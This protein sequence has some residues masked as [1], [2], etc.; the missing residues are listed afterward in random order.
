[1]KSPIK[2]KLCLNNTSAALRE[3]IP[4]GSVVGTHAFFDGKIEFALANNNRFVKAHTSSEL[5]YQFW[6]CMELDSHRICNLATCEDF[7]FDDE[8]MFTSLQDTWHKY[9]SPFVRAAL[10]FL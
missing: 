6:K 1:M 2:N 8:Q 5:V 10:F 3:L 9:T 4:A 7:V